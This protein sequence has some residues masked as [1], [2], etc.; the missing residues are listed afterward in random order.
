MPCLVYMGQNYTGGG[1]DVEANPQETATAELQKLKVGGVV[2]SVSSGLQPLIPYM[3]STTTPSGTVTSSSEYDVNY[4]DWMAFNGS[5]ADISSMTGGWLPSTNDNAPW[6]QYAWSSAQKLSLLTIETANNGTTA[7]RTITVEGL[8]A[9]GTYENCLASGSDFELSFTNGQYV[10]HE[11][12]LNGNEYEA[13][14]IS[15][16]EVWFV[17]FDTACTLSKVQCYSD[18]ED[19]PSLTDLSDTNITSPSDGQALEYDGTADKWVNVAK[20]AADTPTFTE[21]STRAN[22]SGSGETMA[23]ILGKIKKWFTDLKDLAFIAKDGTS[24]TK[25]LR[26][27][28]TWQAFPTIPTVNDK[29]LTIQKNGTQVAQFTANSAS[30]VTANITVPTKVSDLTNDSGF[31]TTDEK[32]TGQT[33]NPT[34]STWYNMPFIGTSNQKPYYNN[35]LRYK[36][37]EGTASATGESIVSIGNSTASGTAG[38]KIGTLRIYSSGTGYSHLTYNGGN[39]SRTHTLPD[40]TGTIALTDD[41]AT[42]SVNYATTAGSAGTATT[43][44]NIQYSGEVGGAYIGGTATGTPTMSGRTGNGYI[45]T[46]GAVVDYINNKLD[47][48]T[49][50]N[51]YSATTTKTSVATYSSRK[52]SDYKMLMFLV[53]DTSGYRASM[54]LPRGT[55][56]SSTSMYVSLTWVDSSNTQYWVEITYKDDTHCYIQAKSNATGKVVN[57]YGLH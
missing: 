23:T 7:T 25:Y 57:V 51:S 4:A 10:S 39:N 21:A 14:R 24:S 53:Y 32:V 31:V 48:F 12:P 38:N 56:T 9:G 27:D 49:V 34:S 42:A 8:T 50:V 37:L 44:T 29:T 40:K 15:G 13:I 54:F 41:F 55:F 20:K 16:D 5:S 28:G 52:F 22:L 30:D 6:I 47:Y 36:T 2:Y 11:I 26:G 46:C 1:T 45:P 35:G 33:Q 18:T 3:T 19:T 43:S 17:L